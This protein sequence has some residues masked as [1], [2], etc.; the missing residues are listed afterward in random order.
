MKKIIAGILLLSFVLISLS[1]CAFGGDR[2]NGGQQESEERVLISNA[3][4]SEYVVLISSELSVSERTAIRLAFDDVKEKYGLAI[5]FR[6]QG[7]K[8]QDVPEACEILVGKFNHTESIEAN[9]ALKYGEYSVKYNDQS[10]RII[11]SGSTGEL[12]VTAFNYFLDNFLDA[13][14]ASI[15]VPRN[16]SYHYQFDHEYDEITIN[17]KD[18]TE[19]VIVI[20][21]FD[22]LFAYYTALNISDF[23]MHKLGYEIRIA[24]DDEGVF[25]YEILVGDT[26]RSEDDIDRELSEREY[27]F[28]EVNGKIVLRGYGIYVGAGLGEYLDSKLDGSSAVVDLSDIPAEKKIVKYVSPE[29]AK[30][31][32]LMIGDGMGKNHINAALNSGLERFEAESFTSAGYV[33]TKSQSVINGDAVATDSAASSTAMST[34]RKTINGYLGKDERGRDIKNVRELAF[35]SGAKTAVVT[36]DNITGATPSGFLV[37]NISRTNTEEIQNDIDALIASEVIEYCEG[38]VTGKLPE[39]MR[40]AIGVIA[41]SDAAFFM[42]A[43]EGQID[44]YSHSNKLPQ[45]IAKV[46]HFNKAIMYA[47]CFV[48]M[49]PEAA[50]IVTADHETGGLVEDS[51][52]ES[53]YTYTT[54]AHTNVNVPIYAI[55]GGTQIFDGAVIDNT[56]IYEFISSHFDKEN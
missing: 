7:S 51:E 6:L 27:L 23:F 30:N 2:I 18:V 31:V 13:E 15:S 54:E 24:D 28:A 52:A 38:N 46:K 49:N 17:K 34:G 48:M 37:H 3:E 55:G 42:M 29:S 43:E 8:D 21:S 41:Y 39:K 22:D 14:T 56:E 16:L 19:Y 40:E 1:S 26:N 36:T 11:I 20:P 25:E 50:L 4:M 53:G 45:A 10:K 44:S 5:D 9:K 33:V 32:I 12:V 47:A 35:E